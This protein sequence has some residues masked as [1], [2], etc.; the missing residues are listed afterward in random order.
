M[1][2][3]AIND[4]TV[5]GG[6]GADELS[7]TGPLHKMITLHNV[8]LSFFSGLTSPGGISENTIGNSILIDF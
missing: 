7:A 8:F 6:T 1:Q 2:L 5:A 3:F 4:D